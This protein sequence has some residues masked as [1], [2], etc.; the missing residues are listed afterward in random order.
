VNVESPR[1]E[2]APDL[3]KAVEIAERVWWV[4][5]HIRGD[6]LQCHSYLVEAGNDSVLIDPGSNLTFRQSLAKI[7]QVIPFSRIRYFVCHDQDPDITAA[8][9]HY[10]AMIGR[11][12]AVIVTHWRAEQLMRHF[13]F[14]T[15]FWRVEEHGWQL[16]LGDRILHFV[17]TPYMPFPV[18]FCTFDDRTGVLFSSNVFGALTR[19]WELFAPTEKHFDAIRMFHEHYMPSREIVANGLAHIE[20]YP[21]RMIAPQHGSIIPER[22]VSFMIAKVKSLECGLYLLAG[23]DTHIERLLEI[24]QILHD[25]TNTMVLYRDFSA[26]VTELLAIARRLLPIDRLEF[27]ARDIEGKTLHLAA[28]TQ[29]RG[30]LAEAPAWVEAALSRPVEPA[31]GHDPAIEVRRLPTGRQRGGKPVERLALV[32]PLLSNDR[33]RYDSVC[34]FWLA[35][36]AHRP[37]LIAQ[38]IDQMALPLAVAVE[39]E[40]IFRRLELERQSIY[41]RSIRD[42]LTG[43]YTRFH[44]KDAV[45]RLMRR[46]DRDPSERLALMMCDVDHFKKFNDTFGHPA[47]DEVLRRI[48]GVLLSESRTVDVPVRIGGEEFAVFV[49]GRSVRGIGILAE[50]VRKKVAEIAFD[51]AL[52]GHRVTISIG[53]AERGRDETLD[54][55][56]ARADKALYRAKAT[57]R[58]RAVKAR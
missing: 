30:V 57:G 8:M 53:V 41:E 58:N 46:Q 36:P 31:A 45:T 42:P 51:G 34:V 4:G 23:Q 37:A 48:G 47:G 17:F 28:E 1:P 32:L 50:R 38:M 9:M 27:F 44:M 5:H 19:K 39:R 13:G 14:R 49:H 24:N 22:L 25:I 35:R 12:D 7:E 2:G 40:V 20:Q 29:Y 18:A 52:A 15:P 16:A 3:D 21:V 54:G 10:D 11:P 26:I 56:I 55:L 43:L 33:Q 6:L